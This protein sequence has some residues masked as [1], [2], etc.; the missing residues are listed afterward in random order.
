MYAWR[1]RRQS[2]VAATFIML[3]CGRDH[4]LVPKTGTQET[5]FAGI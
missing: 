4:F 1:L 3:S 2:L 5:M